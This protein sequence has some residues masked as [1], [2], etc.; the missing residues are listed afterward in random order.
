MNRKKMRKGKGKNLPY[1]PWNQDAEAGDR[2]VGDGVVFLLTESSGWG[3]RSAGEL[4][5]RR[6]KP[7]VE[8]AQAV[9]EDS[10]IYWEWE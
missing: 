7:P 6:I 3:K 8:G 5:A 1:N 9:L 2:M 4:S 10:E